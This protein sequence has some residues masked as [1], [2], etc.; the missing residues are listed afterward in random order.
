MFLC[1]FTLKSGHPYQLC[2][3]FRHQVGSS[4]KLPALSLLFAT[5]CLQSVG[6]RS[7]AIKLLEEEPSAAQQVPLLISLAKTVTSSS[8]AGGVLHQSSDSGEGS[9]DTLARALR[10]A[11]ESGDPDLVYLVLFAAYK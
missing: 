3:Y 8:G 10:K 6:R 11:V 4:G 1:A 5:A 9:E 7:L 2:S